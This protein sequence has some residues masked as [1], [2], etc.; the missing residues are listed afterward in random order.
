MA[1]G[2]SLVLGIDG[3]GTK[4]LAGVVD[5]AWQVRGR[6]KIKSPFRGGPA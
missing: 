5:E 6:G 3:G 2:K 1:D 4:S